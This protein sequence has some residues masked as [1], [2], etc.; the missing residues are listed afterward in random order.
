MVKYGTE[1]QVEGTGGEADALVMALIESIYDR[2]ESVRLAIHESLHSIGKK[3][4]IM[5]LT[6]CE[7][8]LHKHKKVRGL[9]PPKSLGN[10]A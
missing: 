8:Y 7:T 9:C 6:S 4:A 1:P 3:Q 10:S 5:V 2:E